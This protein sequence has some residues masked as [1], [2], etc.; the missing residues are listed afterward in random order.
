MQLYQ[1]LTGRLPFWPKKTLAEVAKLPGYELVAAIRTYEVQFPRALWAGIS[2][3]AQDLVS[4][5]LDRDPAS[6]IT[7]AQALQHPWLSATLGFTPTPSGDP[8]AAAASAA[9]S[10][11][12]NVVEFSR[13]APRSP[14]LRP[15]PLMSPGKGSPPSSSAFASPSSNSNVNSPPPGPLSPQKSSPLRSMLS[16]ELPPSVLMADMHRASSAVMVE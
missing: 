10:S 16:G 9:G 8:V 2:P 1:M 15:V 4:R 13:G 11:S 5:M 3:Q 7:A 6:R 12:N 14:T